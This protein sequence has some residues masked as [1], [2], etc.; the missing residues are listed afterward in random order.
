MYVLASRGSSDKHKQ[1]TSGGVEEWE[2]EREDEM[3][4]MRK[5]LIDGWGAAGAPLPALILQIRLHKDFITVC[6]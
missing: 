2:R 6:V 1:W 3:K 5:V 4:K